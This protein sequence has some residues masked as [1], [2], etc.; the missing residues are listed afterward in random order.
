MVQIKKRPGTSNRRF[1][2]T[3]L[4]QLAKMAHDDDMVMS[5]N[6]HLELSKSKENL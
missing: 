5:F 6:E 3:Q 1:A 4:L 2:N